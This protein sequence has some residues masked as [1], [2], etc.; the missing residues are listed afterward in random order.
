[1]PTKNY[2]QNLTAMQTWWYLGAIVLSL[3]EF[4]V[5]LVTLNH[6]ILTLVLPEEFQLLI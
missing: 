3:M 1:M 4:M 6:L 2:A 5:K